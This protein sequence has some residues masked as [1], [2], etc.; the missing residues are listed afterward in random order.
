MSEF[1]LGHPRG[2]DQLAQRGA[3]RF[4]AKAGRREGIVAAQSRLESVGGR[5]VQQAT[6]FRPG[7]F[8]LRPDGGR[9]L[10]ARHAAGAADCG[11]F[12]V[13]PGALCRQ[14][15]DFGIRLL[16]PLLGLP[17]RGAPAFDL[18]RV[19][20]RHLRQLVGIAFPGS[21]GAQLPNQGFMTSRPGSFRHVA[22][23]RV[24]AATPGLHRRRERCDRG[25][26]SSFGW[27]CFTRFPQPGLR[28]L[29]T[30]RGVP[31][32]L[33]SGIQGLFDARPSFDQFAQ[34]AGD[35]GADYQ[36]AWIGLVLAIDPCQDAGDR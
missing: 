36:P 25:P 9:F 11:E 29:A 34:R 16:D 28:L 14:A 35:R 33:R 5:G 31:Q 32:L 18:D 19:G 24:A 13:M 27:R 4:P 7:A 26:P 3:L 12:G 17:D 8:P 10:L 30:L 2:L 20:R 23:H 21:E 15:V 1:R 22:S 6:V